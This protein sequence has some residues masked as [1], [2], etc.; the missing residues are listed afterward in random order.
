MCSGGELSMKHF[1]VW[2]LST[3]LVAGVGS[4]VMAG[5]PNMAPGQIT[6]VQSVQNLFAPKPPKPLGPS[7]QIAPLTITAPLTPA[8]LTKCLQAEQEAFLRRISV[9]DAL[10]QVADEK[11]DATLTRQ[12]DELEQQA[13][14]L[15]NARVAALGL[16]KTKASLP[17]PTIA[18]Q[19]VEPVA[20]QVAA[21]RL[22]A[23]SA[24][25]PSASTAEIKEVKP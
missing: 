4:Q 16:P 6:L 3:A 5:D 22:I 2:G 17:E 11:G 13:K 20:P 7:G 1:W 10:R 23:P 21:S 12:A 19:L 18:M 8:V 9:C 14:T 25:L 15:Y 24:P